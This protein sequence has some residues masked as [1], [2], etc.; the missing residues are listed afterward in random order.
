MRSEARILAAVLVF[1]LSTPLALGEKAPTPSLV[2]EV[3]SFGGRQDDCLYGCYLSIQVVGGN[4]SCPIVNVTLAKGD[5]VRV[6]DYVFVRPRK[7]A[8]FLLTVD[9]ETWDAYA[10]ETYLGRFPFYGL[11][12]GEPAVSLATDAGLAT[13]PAVNATRVFIAYREY[14]RVSLGNFTRDFPT[15]EYWPVLIELLDALGVERLE[16]YSAEFD[17]RIGLLFDLAS[18]VLCYM[19]VFNYSESPVAILKLLGVRGDL[20]FLQLFK[21]AA[22]EPAIA[23][24]EEA[25]LDPPKKLVKTDCFVPI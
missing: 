10:N 4:L 12:L 1:A 23:L 3:I 21:A 2:Y 15:R 6:R 8:S 17:G 24:A 5:L 11:K 19:Q 25:P 18:G 9:A 14:V 7:V 22:G 13:L 16:L 20:V